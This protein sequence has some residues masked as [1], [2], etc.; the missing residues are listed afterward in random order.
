M[1]QRKTTMSQNVSVAIDIE[2]DRTKDVGKRPRN[3]G[4]RSVH[5]GKQWR[6]HW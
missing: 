4:L 2:V 6:S 3:E 1:L 5:Q